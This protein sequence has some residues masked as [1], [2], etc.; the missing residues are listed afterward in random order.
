[1]VESG[2]ALD[3]ANGDAS[4]CDGALIGTWRAVGCDP[5]DQ[6][7]GRRHAFMKLGE[8]DAMPSEAFVHLDYQIT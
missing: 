1:M 4:T 6:E 3:R 2:Y 5:E 8:S 7:N